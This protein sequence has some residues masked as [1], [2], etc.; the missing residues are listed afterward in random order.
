MGAKKPTFSKTSSTGET[1]MKYKLHPIF[2]LPICSVCKMNKK[3][4]EY[5]CEVDYRSDIRCDN[6]LTICSQCFTSNNVYVCEDHEKYMKKNIAYCDF[7][8]QSSSESPVYYCYPDL[9]MRRVK[10]TE[11]E[12][13]GKIYPVCHNHEDSPIKFSKCAMCLKDTFDNFEFAKTFVFG[14]SELRKD[15]FTL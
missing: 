4:N 12:G 14:L 2:S 8:Q 13:C 11:C 1:L 3:C 7:T 5:P 9:G 6:K 15:N 10:D